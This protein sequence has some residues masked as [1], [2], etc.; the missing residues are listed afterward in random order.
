MH[1]SLR[2]IPPRKVGP[3]DD[4]L[5]DGVSRRILRPHLRPLVL[6][7]KVEELRVVRLTFIMT[8]RMMTMMK[9]MRMMM[10]TMLMMM[11]AMMM[12]LTFAALALHLQVRERVKD[13]HKVIR[14]ETDRLRELHELLAIVRSI[15]SFILRISWMTAAACMA[16]CVARASGDLRAA[17]A[18]HSLLA[19]RRIRRMR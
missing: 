10:M 17:L 8:M 15:S 9:R 4:D 12:K 14:W 13:R 18:T 2:L 1:C 19:S 7:K 3:L 11:T 16:S 5:E 6:D